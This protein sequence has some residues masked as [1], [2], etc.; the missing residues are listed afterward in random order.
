MFVRHLSW[1]LLSACCAV[2]YAAPPSPEQAGAAETTTTL[3][4]E[5]RWRAGSMPPPH[6]HHYSIVG[7]SDGRGAILYVP[8]YAFENPPEWKESFTIAKD[9]L[10]A[11]ELLVQRL[12][13][14]KRTWR[15]VETRAVGGN[16]RFF[17]FE[18]AGK[19]VA[20]PAELSSTDQA[21]VAQLENAVR[22]VVPESVWQSLHERHAEYK[23]RLP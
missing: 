23:K 8:G 13:V 5:Y 21:D 7:S 12:K 2:A 11:L 4:F 22:G 18:A 14:M 15:E 1:L 9:R 6:H 10:D 16:L 19:T 20:I 17:R 3:R